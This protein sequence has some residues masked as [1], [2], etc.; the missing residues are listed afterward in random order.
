MHAPES[1]LRDAEK[2]VRGPESAVQRS[3]IR[4]RAAEMPPRDAETAVHETEIRVR[5]VEISTREGKKLDFS[6]LRPRM[7]MET[8]ARLPSGTLR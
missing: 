7:R 1:R 2:R 3:E 5:G 6:D 4:L 8:P